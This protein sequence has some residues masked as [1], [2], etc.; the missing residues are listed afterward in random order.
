MQNKNIS[1]YSIAPLLAFYFALWDHR[2]KNLESML[3]LFYQAE[4]A[5]KLTSMIRETSGFLSVFSAVIRSL[6][7]RERRQCRMQASV[8]WS[9]S[10]REYIQNHV[11]AMRCRPILLPTFLIL[12]LGWSSLPDN[13]ESDGTLQ[14][15]DGEQEA[16][17][18]IIIMRL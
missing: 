17:W 6:W 12:S 10:G 15:S 5:K 1:L 18:L 13:A 9:R 3:A 7:L 16:M 11:Y 2:A 14:Q 4:G 8:F